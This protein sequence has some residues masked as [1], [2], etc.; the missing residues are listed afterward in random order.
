MGRSCFIFD[1]VQF[2][3]PRILFS[4]SSPNRLE[5]DP[6]FENGAKLLL[7]EKIYG[8]IYRIKFI[9]LLNDKVMKENEIT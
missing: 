1:A 9:L 4:V 3:E 2:N 7:Q 6:F 5:I 8:I